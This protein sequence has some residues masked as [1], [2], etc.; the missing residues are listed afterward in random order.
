MSGPRGIKK[1]AVDKTTVCHSGKAQFVING[2]IR[3]LFGVNLR[4]G[5]LFFR[6]GGKGTPDTIS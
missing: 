5:V 6:Q 4:S 3:G 1:F 2:R